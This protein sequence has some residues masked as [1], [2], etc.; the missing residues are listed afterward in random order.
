M[1]GIRPRPLFFEWFPTAAVDCKTFILTKLDHFN[2]EMI[3]EEL[4]DNIFPHRLKEADKDGTDPNTREYKLLKEYTVKAPSATTIL[5]WIRY[6]GFSRGPFQKSYYVDKHEAP[7]NVEHRSKF[8]DNYLT[9]LEP[10][11]H[12]WVQLT[13]DKFESI[14]QSLPEKVSGGRSAKIDKQGYRYTDPETSEK[15]I[16]FH[17]DDHECL[18]EIGCHPR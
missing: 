7:E 2:A 15:M 6:L 16:E 14:Q 12:R 1:N 17:V 5:K 13:I 18:Q 9:K 10:R 8:I 11:M 4:I 3:R